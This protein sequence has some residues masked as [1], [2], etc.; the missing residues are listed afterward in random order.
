MNEMFWITEV[1]LSG[2]SVTSFSVLMLV[3]TVILQY[4]RLTGYLR[5]ITQ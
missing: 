2:A 1:Q 3:F 4:N 5:H